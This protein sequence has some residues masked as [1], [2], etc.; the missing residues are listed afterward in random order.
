MEASGK[1]E[2]GGHWGWR[3]GRP[4]IGGMSCDLRGPMRGSGETPPPAVWPSPTSPAL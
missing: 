4:G 1:N 3:R 2:A